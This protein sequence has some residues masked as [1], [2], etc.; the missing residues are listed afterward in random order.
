[1]IEELS[2][3]RENTAVVIMDY[4]NRQLSH[5]SEEFQRELLERANKVLERARYKGIPVINVEVIRGERTPETQIHPAIAPRPGETLLTKRRV[6]P[7]ST[8]N[9]DKVLKTHGIDTL[10]LLGISTSGCVL[11]TVRCGA[12]MDYRIIVLS[13]CCA[14]RDDEVQRVLMEKVFPR[15]ARVITSQQFLQALEKS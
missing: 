6:G 3:S 9:L 1:M 8:T 10:V 14:D 13:D 11:S 2:T 5:F 12:D 15:Q 4:Q 7:F